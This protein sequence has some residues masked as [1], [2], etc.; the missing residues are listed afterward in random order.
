MRIDLLPDKFEGRHGRHYPAALRRSMLD[1]ATTI[2]DETARNRMIES[3]VESNDRHEALMRQLTYAHCWR[4][5]ESESEAM[6]R[7]Y[8][9]AGASVALVL[10]YSRLRDSLADKTLYIGRVNYFDYDKQIVGDANAYAPLMHKRLEFEHE[11]E[12]RI[13]KMDWSYAEGDPDQKERWRAR[14]DRP[15]V[16]AIPWPVAEH[17]ESVIVSPYASRWQADTIREA[18]SRLAPGLE[19]RVINSR[20][21]AD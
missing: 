12:I 14:P 21:G 3:L 15:A 1:L 9:G 4:S 6:W 11:Q 19:Q 13:L 17:V 8:G 16:I 18:V 20:M 10:P 5:G 7:I 2:S